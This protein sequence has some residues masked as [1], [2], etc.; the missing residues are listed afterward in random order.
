ME[1]CLWEAL[2]L[3]RQRLEENRGVVDTMAAPAAR[4][5]GST[6][7]AASRRPR[8][9]TPHVETVYE[10]AR[11]ASAR[12]PGRPA[13]GARERHDAARRA[14]PR[15]PT[16]QPGLGRRAAGRC[17]GPARLDQHRAR[18]RPTS[19][20]ATGTPTPTR[21]RACC[22]S[23]A[24]ARTRWR[25]SSPASRASGITSAWAPRTA[26]SSPRSG[27]S[28]RAS[29][30]SAAQARRAALGLPYRTMI[31]V[32]AHAGLKTGE[33]GP[34]HADPQALQLLQGNFPPGVAITLTPWEPQE[35]WPLLCAALAQRPALLAP[36]V[37]RPSETVL[38]RRAMGLAPA[39]AAVD[40]PLPAPAARATRRR[41]HRAS[42]ERRHVR[43]RARGAA[44]A[45]PRRN[46]TLDLLR[47]ERGAVRRAAGGAAAGRSSR[48]SGAAKPWASPASR[49][50]RW[51]AGSHSR[52]GRSLTLHPYQRGHY[53]GSGQGEMVLAEAGLDGA[54]QYRAVRRYVESR[55]SAA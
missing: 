47:G 7:G 36:F 37:T 8:E 23:A 25:A 10:L 34:T 54:S 35:I 5:S 44:A 24:S 19:R 15:A 43:V 33:D 14:G 12:D 6:P 21:T 20:P 22:P 42:G 29:T 9:R 13:P 16:S 40:G 48:T 18:R 45:G 11:G 55:R 30:A 38:D 52:L 28:P 32:C 49:C 4:G 31:L 51:I 39:E 26:P 53:L 2:G 27:T 3:V 1:Q 46:L 50:P 41:D 17:R